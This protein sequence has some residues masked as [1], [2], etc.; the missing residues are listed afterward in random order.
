MKT[1]IFVYGTLKKGNHNHGFLDGA[2]F[3]GEAWTKKE[4]TLLED[5][6]VGLPYVIKDESYSI[7]GELYEVDKYTFMT[8]DNL[9]GHPHFYKRELVECFIPELN[10]TEMKAWLYFLQEYDVQAVRKL[11]TGLW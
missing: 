5:H 7:Q 8:L 1:I 6:Y 4:Y 2:S 11:P 3:I 9:E 10:H